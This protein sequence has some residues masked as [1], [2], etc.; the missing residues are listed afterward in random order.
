MSEMDFRD[1]SVGRRSR[2]STALTAVSL[3][4][5]VASMIVALAA[6]SSARHA[7]RAVDGGGQ[8]AATQQATADAAVVDLQAKIDQLSTKVAA[9]EGTLTAQLAALNSALGG[10]QQDVSSPTSGVLAKLSE[11]RQCLSQFFLNGYVNGA[12]KSVYSC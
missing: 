1:G 12:V 8:A 6:I 10:V 3:L 4:I 5:A 7:T 11:F 2:G 9:L